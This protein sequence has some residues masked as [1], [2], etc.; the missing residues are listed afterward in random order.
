M[1]LPQQHHELQ[2]A[3]ISA[4]ALH[5]PTNGNEFS[6]ATSGM[7]YRNRRSPFPPLPTPLLKGK[8]AWGFL[9]CPM[10]WSGLDNVSTLCKRRKKTYFPL[11]V[12]VDA[13]SSTV[14]RLSAVQPCNYC[15]F[16]WRYPFNS[17]RVNC[18]SVPAPLYIYCAGKFGTFV[19]DAELIYKTTSVLQRAVTACNR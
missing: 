8:G 18:A 17:K 13:L 3:G 4:V 5:F 15:F 16:G 6:W 10:L 12:S 14:V 2:F 1:T 19:C 7:S 11:S 9:P